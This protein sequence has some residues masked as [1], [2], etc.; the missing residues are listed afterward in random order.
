MTKS[1]RLFL[2]TSSKGFH[3]TA[4]SLAIAFALALLT[5]QPAPAQTFTVLHDFTGGLDGG[6]SEA[7]L[8]PD[9]AGN[10]YGTTVLGGGSGCGG[11]GCGTVFKL[12]HRNSNWVVT[13][14]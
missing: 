13:P 1:S 12:V 7:G 5:A 11:M 6:N 2:P 10:F 3:W 9:R 8:T 14:I 4:F